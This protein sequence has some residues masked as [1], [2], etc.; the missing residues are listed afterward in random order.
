MIDNIDFASSIIQGGYGGM[1]IGISKNSDIRLEVER[2]PEQL[3]S[4]ETVKLC[5]QDN[6]QEVIGDSVTGGKIKK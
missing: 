3:P 5:R 4:I 1:G 2:V 6:A